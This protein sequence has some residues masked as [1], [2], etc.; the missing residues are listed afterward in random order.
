MNNMKH[1][2]EEKELNYDFY[3]AVKYNDYRD[4]EA[5]YNKGANPNYTLPGKQHSA[6]ELAEKML[7]EGNLDYRF[8]KLL[9]I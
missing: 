6:K 1:F 2:E 7:K 4:A 3:Y 5:L 8:K 9:N